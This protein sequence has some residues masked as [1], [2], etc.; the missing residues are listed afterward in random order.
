[1]AMKSIALKKRE[2]LPVV[3]VRIAQSIAVVEKK[4]KASAQYDEQVVRQHQPR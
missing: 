2:L 1:M 3:I 4:G